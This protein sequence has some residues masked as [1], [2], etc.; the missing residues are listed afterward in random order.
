MTLL[1]WADLVAHRPPFDRPVRLTIGVFDGVHVG[2]RRLFSE[3]I[4]GGPGTLSLVMTFSQSPAV[5]RS[6]GSFPGSILTYRQKI[7]RIGSLGVQAAVVIDFSEEMSNLSGEAFVRLLR[8]NLTIQRIVVGQNFRFGKKRTS[9]TDDLMEMLSD[10]GIEVLVTEPVL[11]E[12]SMVSSSRI[13]AAILSGELGEARQMLAAGHTID[14]RG[15]EARAANGMVRVSRKDIVQ[16][17]P[18]DGEYPVVVEGA[19]GTLPGT[20]AVGRDMLSLAV[21]EGDIL[22]VTGP[23]AAMRD[24]IAAE[25]T[26]YRGA[27]PAEAVGLVVFT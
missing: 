25:S 21:T 2:H 7:E 18:P 13:R 19:A 5:L 17:L 4:T 27:T 9:G 3:I 26:E 24:E 16:V 22:A 10:T 1:T 14:L 6:P 11:R 8:K 23:E 15:I 20:C 12:G